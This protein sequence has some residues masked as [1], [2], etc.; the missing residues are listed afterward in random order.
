MI[1]AKFKSFLFSQAE[2]LSAVLLIVTSKVKCIFETLSGLTNMKEFLSMKSCVDNTCKDL[3]SCLS[4]Y[5]T[6]GNRNP[7]VSYVCKICGL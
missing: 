2:S 3:I 1:L 4:K 5:S 7:Q 6:F